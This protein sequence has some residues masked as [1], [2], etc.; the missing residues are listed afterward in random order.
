MSG[1]RKNDEG[2]ARFDLIP[3]G[4]LWEVARVY[5]VGAKNYGDRDWEDGMSWGRCFAAMMRH[6]W[7]WWGGETYDSEDKQHHLAAVVWYAFTLMEYEKTHPE[8]DDRK[9]HDETGIS[10]KPISS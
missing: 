9:T 7:K 4:P 8:L 1:A 3:V 5:T 10:G 2:K 6:S